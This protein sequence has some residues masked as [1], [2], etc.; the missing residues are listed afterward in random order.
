MVDSIEEYQEPTIK[1]VPP[2]NTYA[3]LGKP[4]GNFWVRYGYLIRMM[5]K[6]FILTLIINAIVSVIGLWFTADPI[7][8]LL[9][10]IEF[11]LIAFPI[12]F[13][14]LVWLL[15]LSYILREK[16]YLFPDGHPYQ[17]TKLY[18]LAL[19]QL[20]YQLGPSRHVTK[21]DVEI[22]QPIRRSMRGKKG[23]LMLFYPLNFYGIKKLFSQV[24]IPIPED[25]QEGDLLRIYRFG[26][27]F[28]DDYSDVYLRFYFVSNLRFYGTLTLWIMVLIAVAFSYTWLIIWLV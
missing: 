11:A 25:L 9:V 7:G 23:E 14:F 16:A 2:L 20:S 10:L 28:D 12:L 27:P 26:F 15:G 24:D 8:G 17:E 19:G 1:H 5:T 13:L 6:T 21:M 4:Y 3:A 22:T 18:N